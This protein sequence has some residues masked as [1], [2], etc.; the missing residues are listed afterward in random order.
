MAR[1][2]LISLLIAF[3]PVSIALTYLLATYTPHDSNLG[4]AVI[5]S[6]GLLTVPGCIAAGVAYFLFSRKH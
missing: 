1:R 3:G 2:I 6:I 4:G 5:V